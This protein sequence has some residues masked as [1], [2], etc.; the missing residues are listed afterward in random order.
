MRNPACIFFLKRL[1]TLAV[2]AL[3]AG[4]IILALYLGYL[5]MQKGGVIAGEHVSRLEQLIYELDRSR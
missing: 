1:A 4:G 5:T 2:R 3:I